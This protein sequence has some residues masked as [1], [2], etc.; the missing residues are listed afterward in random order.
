MTENKART[1]KV[2]PKCKKEKNLGLV[3]CWGCFKYIDNPWKGFD[4][5]FEE[6]LKLNNNKNDDG[7]DIFGP[8]A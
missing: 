2:C 7:L 8:E 6:W 5:T 3:V 4:G 1:L